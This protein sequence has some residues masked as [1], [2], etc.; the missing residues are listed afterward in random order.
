M[1]SI[2]DLFLHS[3]GGI[4]EEVVSEIRN[5]VNELR[6]DAD[7]S[8]FTEDLNRM[9]AAASVHIFVHPGHGVCYIYADASVLMMFK[10]PVPEEEANNLAGQLIG[11]MYQEKDEIAALDALWDA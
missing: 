1:N 3:T 10:H 4:S 6:R 11:K 8:M 2:S 5:H 9:A 7:G